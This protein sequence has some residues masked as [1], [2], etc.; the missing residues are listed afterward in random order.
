VT[1]D[2]SAVADINWLF[3]EPY[4]QLMAPNLARVADGRASRL[5]RDRLDARA[6]AGNV[7]CRGRTGAAPWLVGATMADAWRSVL[8]QPARYRLLTPSDALANVD[9]R[10]FAGWRKWLT[11]PYLM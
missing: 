7:A 1:G 8:R 5:R 2:G 4:Y 3:Y 6:P 11:Y 9:G 10:C